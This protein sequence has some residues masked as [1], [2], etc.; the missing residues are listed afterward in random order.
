MKSFT[1]VLRGLQTILLMAPDTVVNLTNKEADGSDALFYE[2]PDSPPFGIQGAQTRV[3]TFLPV[4]TASYGGFVTVL[5]GLGV[6]VPNLSAAMQGDIELILYAIID[7][8]NVDG[9]S[10]LQ[11]LVNKWSDWRP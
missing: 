7:D 6:R 1:L 11:T 8:G 5:K 9:I 4:A 10:K 3:G 2:T